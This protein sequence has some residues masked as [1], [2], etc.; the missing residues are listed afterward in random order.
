MD[1]LSP[2]V[3]GP[4]GQMRAVDAKFNH[5]AS[6]GNIAMLPATLCFEHLAK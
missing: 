6:Y 3:L 5:T 4:C 1:Y 2:A